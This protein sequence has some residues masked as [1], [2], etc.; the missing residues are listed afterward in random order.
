MCKEYNGWSNRETWATMLWIN[1][2]QG[3]TEQVRFLAEDALH[4]DEADSPI[5]AKTALANALEEMFNEL[6]DF[7]N[8]FSN[9]ALYVVRDDIGS[10][11][12]VDWYEI[13]EAVLSE[14]EV[15]A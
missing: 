13:A 10:M 2:E 15:S 3:L 8:L 5:S 1:N 12:R 11:Y 4:P 7:D 9:R 6:F 14:I